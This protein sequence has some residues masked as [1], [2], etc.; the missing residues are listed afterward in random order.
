[1]MIAMGFLGDTSELGFEGS[2][3]VRRVGSSVEH[4]RVGD[5]VVVIYPGL[6][7]TKKVVPAVSCQ[8]VP[9]KMSLEDAAA[10]SCIYATAIYCLI[11]M[12]NLRKDQSVLIHSACGGV[13]LAAIQV[14]RMIG[15]EIYTTVGTSEKVSY[16]NDTVG[17]PADHIFDSRS[18]SFL[19]GVLKKTNGRGVDLVLNSLSGELLHASWKCVAK[20]GKMIEIGKRDFMGHG[21]LDM[22]R[23]L[24]NRSFIGVDLSIIGHEDEEALGGLVE[25]FTGYFQQGK[26]TPIRPVVVFDALNVV[27]A[28]RHM[29]TGQHIGKIVVR[30]PEDPNTLPMTKIHEATPLFRPD[31]SYLLVG[32]LGGLGR[33]VSI[34]MVEKG[35][36]NLI[37]L[38][39]SGGK[40][41]EA[42]AFI[43]DL[44]SHS[45]VS[46]TV[47]AGDVSN[48]EDVQR[49]LSA[50]KRPI[51]GVLQMSMVLKVSHSALCPSLL[52]STNL[53]T[54]Q[55]QI[56][57]KMTYE[58][59][60]AALTPKV[61]GT[62]NLHFELQSAPLD[63]FVLFSSVTGTMGFASQAN[64]AAANTFLDSFV[65][66]RHSQGLPASVID[67]GF[68][69]DIGYA[70][71]QSPQT[72]NIVN[73]MDIQII[74]EKELLQALEISVFAQS[75][76][77][78]SQ[79]V[80]GLGTMGNIKEIQW[81]HEGRLSRWKNTSVT[82]KAARSSQSH[83]LQSLLGEIQ[84]NPKLL[85]EQSTHD[86]ITIEL[87]KVVAAHLA[88]AEDLSKE[89]LSNIAIDSLMSI[90]IRSWF[91]R[92]AGIDISLVEISNAGT[93]GGLADT[94]VK[95]LRKKHSD[96]GEIPSR[97]SAS[98]P[99]EPDEMTVCLE[100]MKLGS[101]LRA[102][103]GTVP[104][105]CSESEGIVFLTGATGFVGAFFL[106]EL[107]ALPQV[108]SVACLIRTTD[109]L[110]GRL[111][112]EKT[113]T[114]YGLPLE[115]LDKITVVPGNIAHPNLG[116]SKEEFNHHARSSS[117]VFH[118]GAYVNYTLPYSAH[119]DANIVG[120]LN[121]LKFVNT[122][123]LKSLNYFSSIGACGASAHLTG[124]TI[125]ENERAMLDPK[126][127]EQ[128]VGYTRSKLA[129]ESIAW[130]AIANKIPITIY[131]PGVVMGHSGTG[132]DKPED[133]FNRLMYNCIR[134]G[135]YPAP[136][137]QL[138]HFVPVDYVCAAI[139]RISQSPQNQG[140]AFNVV[141]PNQDQAITWMDT[142]KILSD[143]GSTPLRCVSVTEWL[144]MFAAQGK[145]S[146][147]TATPLLKERLA[148]NEIWWG[149]SSGMAAYETTNLRRALADSPDILDIK[150]MPELLKTYYGR[151]EARAM[152]TNGA[153]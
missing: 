84:K 68:M 23:F 75:P 34:W 109:P 36:R 31:A 153:V 135:A 134:L 126:Y 42:Q 112:I 105:W 118:L 63:F 138:N 139:L 99:A 56:L 66:Y 58:D 47:I 39:R 10:I 131:R 113:F 150:P 94:A 102:L 146:M 147:K 30:M 43:N 49:A 142:F 48:I 92:N 40:S 77:P 82:N 27:K 67:L 73:T 18:T 64:Y 91:R 145:H 61:Q 69:A 51:A 122:G 55:D 71:E 144:Q 2:G 16:L 65:Q 53:F 22:D 108:K 116:M 79:L 14:C 136:P 128:H 78:S 98:L 3:I 141:Q 76:H 62:W 46:A 54:M 74:E 60:V 117:V 96:E 72:L 140:H 137:D 88:Y 45:M 15:A 24:G 59:W 90:E 1:M 106:L 81:S 7:G 8:P 35:A 6:L 28:F 148:E 44:E 97:I 32:G 93:V 143:H 26:L 125:P 115:V 151:W 25:Q 57:S 104:D 132:V 123:R 70:A 13:G 120:L 95:M 114:R 37:F 38:S 119:R 4:I 111:R 89:E 101:D 29:Q 110:S 103:P 52:S 80:V 124:T 21:K 129:A 41:P 11:T 133:L 17:I 152:D 100:D 12:G 33:A 20:F 107:L 83:A 121:M 9:E 149:D 50:A 127:F 85:D 5:K 130:N 19:Q 87:G 86:K